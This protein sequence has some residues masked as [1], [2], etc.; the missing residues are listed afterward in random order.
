MKIS[1]CMA[2]YNGAGHIG[3]QI[4]SILPQ[5]A[6]GDELIIVDD[7]SS[8]ATV[9]IIEGFADSRIKL[10]LN[11]ANLGTTRTFDKA[12]SLA[13]G[14]LIFLSDQDDLWYEHKVATVCSHFESGDL[15]LI[16]HDARVTSEKMVISESLF[17]MYQSSP[18]LI[19]NIISSTHTGC[20]MAMRRSAL[21]EL[22]PIP[23]K[24][25]IFHDSWIGVYSS[26]LRHK[27]LF[28][29]VPLIDYQRHAHNVSAMRR[30]G[31][32]KI[33]PERINLILTLGLRLAGRFLRGTG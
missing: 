28:L 21:L 31:I 18:G 6:Q 22:L 19:R 27:K 29:K 16:V 4:A 30:R 20:C 13:K 2:A 9:K 26:C 24:R 14:D 33:I 1:V 15:D 5:L 8:D 32:M 12:L 7:A 25:G 3:A 10:Y 23:Y 17:A 11:R